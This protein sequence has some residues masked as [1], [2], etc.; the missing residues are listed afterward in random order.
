MRPDE[1]DDDQPAMPDFSFDDD[2]QLNHENFHESKS[3]EIP[4]SR[5]KQ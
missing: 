5:D 1:K 3:M 2:L 4:D